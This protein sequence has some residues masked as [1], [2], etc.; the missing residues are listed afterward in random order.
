MGGECALCEGDVDRSV[1]DTLKNS[2]TINDDSASRRS[3]DAPTAP[4]AGRL[5]VS[6][7]RKVNTLVPTLATPS[8][9][10][11]VYTDIFIPSQQLAADIYCLLGGEPRSDVFYIPSLFEDGF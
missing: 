2:Q 4:I 10:L 11:I 9:L 3:P 6:E 5:T 8:C 1:F 7:T